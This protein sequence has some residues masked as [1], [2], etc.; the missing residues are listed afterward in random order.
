MQK[1]SALIVNKDEHLCRWL[2]QI[3]ISWRMSAKNIVNPR[4]MLDDIKKHHYN[5]IL[6]DVCTS[7]GAETE[8]LGSVR[9]LCPQTKIISLVN[10]TDTTRIV[11]VLQGGAFDFLAKPISLELLRHVVMGYLF[12]AGQWGVGHVR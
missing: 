12:K 3:L 8:L 10:Q 7:D 9:E 5:V 1:P 2:K 4:T 6:F 11:K